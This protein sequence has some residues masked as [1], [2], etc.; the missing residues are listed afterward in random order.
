MKAS[1]GLP[2][3]RAASVAS[4][5]S[6]C[7]LARAKAAVVKDVPLARCLG[8]NHD[9]TLRGLIG[10]VFDA[11]QLSRLAQRRPTLIVPSAQKLT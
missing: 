6:S 2:Y 4:R 9:E 5:A 3:A 7:P 1:I 8:R 11:H 10:F